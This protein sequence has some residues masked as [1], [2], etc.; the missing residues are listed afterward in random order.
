MPEVRKDSKGRRLRP[1]EY[2]RE[3]GLYAYAYTLY[4]KRKWLYDHDLAEL[5]KKAKKIEKDR[6]DGIR[7]QEASKITLN[8]MFATYMSTKDRLKPS[9]LSNYWYLWRKYLQNTDMAMKPIGNIRKSEVT[10]FYAALLKGGFSYHS[11]GNVNNLIYPTLELAVDDDLIRKNPS[12]GVYRSLKKDDAKIREALTIPQQH[13][14][15]DFIVNSPTYHH[16]ATVFVTLL[17]TGLRVGECVGLTKS[18]ILLDKKLISVNHTLI[19]RQIEGKCQFLISTP[20]TEKGKRFVPMIADVEKYLIQHLE[21]LD[22]LYPTPSP[23]IQGYT[24]FIF[25]NRTGDLLNPHCLNRAIERIC[26]DYNAEE[27]EFAKKEHREPLLLPHFS[28][29]NLRHTFCTRLFEVEQDHKFIQQ[30]MGH[31]DISTTLDIYTHITDE[32]FNT[33][34]QSLNANISLF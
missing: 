16:W 2:E 27:I 13:A 10:K 5:R 11:L 30:V 6:D 7:T 4:G 21:I 31:A 1:G 18:D 3:D 12:K 32:K 14:F 34:V 33:T 24:D 17:G 8:D 28:V 25:R 23:E 19:Y 26:R 9:T 20:K 29:H 15:L 22:E